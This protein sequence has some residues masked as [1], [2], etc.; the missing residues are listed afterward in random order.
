MPIYL[1][2]MEI[3]D[4]IIEEATSQFF[5]YG[6]RNITMD[7]M[8]ASVGISKRTLYETFKDKTE[9]VSTCL[10]ALEQKHDK[11]NYQIISGSANVIEAMFVLMKQGIKMMN[12]VNP[13]FFFDLK[14]YYPEIWQSLHKEHKKKSCQMTYTMLRKGLNEGLYR[15]GINIEIIAK[16]FHEQMNLVSDETIFPSDKFDHGEVFQNIM[17]NFTRGIAT[18]RG[19]EIID[20]IIE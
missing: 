5:K 7:E 10:A 2:R 13:V 20:E 11:I 1:A 8:A 18:K 3:R 16:L 17:I 12:S 14:K 19:I 4:R 6:I 15:K 9:L